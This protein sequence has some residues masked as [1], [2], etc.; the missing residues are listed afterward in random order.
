MVPTE[1][2][3]P[4]ARPLSILR[5]SVLIVAVGSAAQD[6]AATCLV[7]TSA[8]TCST[9]LATATGVFH[10]PCWKCSHDDAPSRSAWVGPFR[11]LRAARAHVDGVRRPIYHPS[12]RLHAMIRHVS[13][14]PK[15]ARLARCA[16][17]GVCCK[18]AGAAHE[19]TWTQTL[20]EC[21]RK[22]RQC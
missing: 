4:L 10:A 2:P 15:D 9:W 8:G 3:T 20:G 13:A 22:A 5:L 1:C 6:L 12:E 14:T 11:P 21:E 7:T 18:V 16:G 17:V 19:D